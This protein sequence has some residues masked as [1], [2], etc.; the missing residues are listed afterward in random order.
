MKFREIIERIHCGTVGTLGRC[1]GGVRV[2]ADH[3]MFF[4]K[5]WV[6]EESFPLKCA[7][8]KNFKDW[9]PKLQKSPP[10][11]P[12]IHGKS[13]KNRWTILTRSVEIPLE[14]RKNREKNKKKR[15]SPDRRT[16]RR[17]AGGARRPGLVPV[18]RTHGF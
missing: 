8:R 12:E 10:T 13:T 11:P 14:I 3:V 17:V 18:E 7:K 2:A 5:S 4:L 1:P 15:K 6:L 9:W 16:K